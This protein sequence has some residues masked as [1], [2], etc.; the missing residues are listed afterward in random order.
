MSAAATLR[1]SLEQLDHAAD[2]ARRWKQP[3]YVYTD[4]ACDFSQLCH[5]D[6]CNPAEWMRKS[7][8]VWTVHPD[9]RIDEPAAVSA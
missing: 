1:P 2:N 7:R 9:G 3:C 6:A 5:Y 8:R 4:S